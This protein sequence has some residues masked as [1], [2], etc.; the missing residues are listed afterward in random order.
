L[1]YGTHVS[2]S[3]D[4]GKE[5]SLPQ[6]MFTDTVGRR[7]TH[8]VRINRTRDGTLVGLGARFYRDVHPGHG[9]TNRD[10]LG[11]VPVDVILLRSADG[12]RT[13]EG[14][15]TID[16]P[17][18][19]PSFEICHAILELPDGRW[20]APMG[21][22]KN[23]KGEAPNGMKAVALVSRDQGATWPEYMDVMDRH[24]EG[25]IHF[26]Q[27]ITRLSDDRLLAVAWAFHEASGSTEPTPYAV[28][29]DGKT[30]S[31]PRPTGLHGQTAKIIALPDGGILCL[32]RRHDK[33]GLWAN[34]SRM[35]GDTWIN[36]AETPL[37]QGAASGMIGRPGADDLS[38]LK[39]GFPSMVVCPNE[40]VLAVFWCCEDCIH[41]IRWLRIRVDP[42]NP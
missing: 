36:L 37:W 23:W 12:G 14:P 17:L 15:R 28:S 4:G 1:D 18:V 16:P 42:I 24:C 3:T 2:H 39:F 27:S 26:E 8:S 25:V 35:D 33:P 34:L 32:Y 41:N 40:E 7:A 10:N 19:G 9:L 20:L 31:P 13:W 38:S 11:Y 29:N 22:W 5:W 30:F 6:R 21:T